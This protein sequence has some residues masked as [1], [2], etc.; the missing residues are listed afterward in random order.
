MEPLEDSFRF[1]FRSKTNSSPN[2]SALSLP[3]V[4]VC[5][6]SVSLLSSTRLFEATLLRV[7]LL[8]VGQ[9]TSRGVAIYL[10]PCSHGS[11]AW[12]LEVVLE[13]LLLFGIR[14]VALIP[15]RVH[16]LQHSVLRSRQSTR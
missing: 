12:S 14:L 1:V 5:F 6:I 7:L 3:N 8:A 11:V 16:N 15:R 2:G 4:A 9:Y 13:D 10:K